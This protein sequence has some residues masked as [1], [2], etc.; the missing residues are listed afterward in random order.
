MVTVLRKNGARYLA[1]FCASFVS[2]A[3]SLSA[4]CMSSPASAII[5]TKVVGSTP[6][7]PSVKAESHP[8]WVELTPAQRIALSPLESEWSKIDA[9]RKK[10]WLEISSRYASM[11]PDEQQ[12]LQE[13]MRIWAKLSPEQRR[14]AREVYSRTKSLDAEQKSAE[15]QQYQKLPEN[16]KKRLAK[17][18]A[19]KKHVAN[20]PTVPA[21]PIIKPPKVLASPDSKLTGV[22]GAQPASAASPAS[23]PVPISPIPSE[24]AAPTNPPASAVPAK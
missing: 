20:L 13:K 6:L 21:A 7:V 10:K 3:M 24:L 8:F 5:P 19:A 15:W 17:D 4:A 1:G 12:R 2:L 22:S 11:K 23:A 16:E 18:I 14:H 9:F